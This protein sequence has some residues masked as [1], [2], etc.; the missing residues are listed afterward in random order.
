MEIIELKNTASPMNHSV[1][2]IKSRVEMTD[3]KSG[4]LED[5]VE[6]TQSA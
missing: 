6:F 5:T 4:D 3:D 1:D 2:G